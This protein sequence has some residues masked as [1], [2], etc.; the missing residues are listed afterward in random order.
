[1]TDAPMRI[2]TTTSLAAALRQAV[3]A[4]MPPGRYYVEVLAA[5]QPWIVGIVLLDVAHG[6]WC[7]R[8]NIQPWEAAEPDYRAR[9]V[10][11][12]RREVVRQRWIMRAG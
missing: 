2:Q 4:A 6:Y 1:M 12:L 3:K 7:V 10:R 5:A 8:G 11:D 9:F